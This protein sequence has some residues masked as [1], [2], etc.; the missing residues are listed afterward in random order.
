LHDLIELRFRLLE[1]RR[2]HSGLAHAL[3]LA[4]L[5]DRRGIGT[6][7]A[8]IRGQPPQI[9]LVPIGEDIDRGYHCVQRQ[10]IVDYGGEMLA[11]PV[12]Q[13]Q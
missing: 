10:V 2:Q 6:G 5:R 12:L 8:Q 7:L 13:Q 1:G 11:D 3:G 9:Q 4:L